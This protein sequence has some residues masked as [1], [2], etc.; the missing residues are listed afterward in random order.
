MRFWIRSYCFFGILWLISIWIFW[1]LSSFTANWCYSLV[2]HLRALK[3]KES[4]ILVFHMVEIWALCCII[5]TF[6]KFVE[7][8]QRKYKS[9]NMR[10]TWRCTLSL[11]LEVAS[12]LMESILEIIRKNLIDIGLELS[13]PKAKLVVSKKRQIYFEGTVSLKL[14]STL[15]W[16]LK[17]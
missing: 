11:I 13:S 5:C 8:Y 12:H 2:L 14:I 15:L 17:T 10:I 4:Y 7:I 6:L 1:F 3:E 16:I 9:L